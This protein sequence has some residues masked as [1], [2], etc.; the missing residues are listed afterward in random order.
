M[1]ERHITVML[2]AIIAFTAWLSTL[3]RFHDF[4]PA[5]LDGAITTGSIASI[6]SFLACAF[7]VT[8]ALARLYGPL[9]VRWCAR[10]YIEVFRGTSLLVQLFWLFFVLPT[11]GIWLA[12]FTVAVLALGLNTG[13]YGA[14]IIR[15]AIEAVPRGQWEASS[16][17]NMTRGQA[18]HRIILPQA[19]VLM[20]PP[21]GNLFIEL[22]KSTALVSLITIPDLA[23]RASEINTLTMKTTDIFVLVLLAYFAMSLAITILMRLVQ[24]AASR[25]VAPGGAP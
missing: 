14:E 22:L 1:G 4:L 8:A 10:G 9:P 18:L 7:G 17:V 3:E 23:F 24:S 21:W 2:L 20:A 19:V 5:L 15:A 25:G 12:P 11:F 13:A 6:A 16:A